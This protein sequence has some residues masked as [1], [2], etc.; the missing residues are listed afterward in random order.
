M[1]HLG[2]EEGCV[3]FCQQSCV[4]VSQRMLWSNH[5]THRGQEVAQMRSVFST[6][7]DWATQCVYTHRV[8]I[9]KSAFSQLVP[10]SLRVDKEFEEKL[11]YIIIFTHAHVISN[12]YS[13]FHKRFNILAWFSILW[14]WMKTGIVKLQN[15]C[16]ITKHHKNGSGLIFQAF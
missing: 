14:K 1:T 2:E 7:S 5:I 6:Q 11:R 8:D 16:K 9:R 10:F 4:R 3:V 12:L 13:F 15:W